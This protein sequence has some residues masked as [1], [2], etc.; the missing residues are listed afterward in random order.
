MIKDITMFGESSAHHKI[1]Y[2]QKIQIH[3]HD[4]GIDL[5]AAGQPYQIALY[6]H[7][8]IINVPTKVHMVFP[9]GH[10][11]LI[12][13]RSSSID[14]LCGGLVIEAVIDAGYTGEMKVRIMC[15]REDFSLVIG[16][17]QECALKEI[18]IAQIVMMEYTTPHFIMADNKPV[19]MGRGDKG[20]G[21]TD[22]V[23]D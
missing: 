13:P 3:P 20:F 1:R 22:L 23:T 11:G 19:L 18:A 8:H 5:F 15:E 6:G 9:E 16:A 2:D 4:C 14:R 12:K 7:R 17:I 21:S 10:Y